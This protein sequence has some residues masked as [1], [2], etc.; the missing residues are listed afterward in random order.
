MK[1]VL[2]IFSMALTGLFMSNAAFAQVESGAQITFEK[3]VHDYGTI[4]QYGNGTVEFKFT[5]TGNAPL[6]ISDAKGSCG[7]TVPEWPKEPIAPGASGSIKVKY[8]TKRVGPFGKS[9]TLQ[10]NATNEPTKT[11][12]IRGTVEAAPQTG[13]PV[14]NSGAPAN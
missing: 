8:D 14:N 10:S 11:L 1:K 3:D 2:F 4:K 7:C 6:L 12:R 13:A 5:N 9:V